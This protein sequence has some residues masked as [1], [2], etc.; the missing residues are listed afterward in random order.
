MFNVGGGELFVILLVA[1]IVLGPERLPDAVRKVG[2]FVGEL[3]SMSDGFQREL[4]AA[5][6]EEP[7]KPL[8]P[9]LGRPQLVPVPDPPPAGSGAHVASPSDAEGDEPAAADDDEP[10][11]PRS[12]DAGG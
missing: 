5:V 8:F 10:E 6:E 3:R 1:L 12:A 9:P 7:G 4:R 2:R 11:A